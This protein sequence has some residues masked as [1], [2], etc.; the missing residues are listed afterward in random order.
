MSIKK[1]KELFVKTGRMNRKVIRDEVALSWY[2]CHLNHMV[3]N[4]KP[5]V[6]K[7]V[8]VTIN[9][10]LNQLLDHLVPISQDYYLA[11]DKLKVTGYRN[12][13]Y[14]FDFDTLEDH[15]IGTNAGAIA[16]K[17]NMQFVVEKEEHFLEAISNHYSV[18]LPFKNEKEETMVLMLLSEAKPSVY[19]INKIQSEVNQFLKKS[20]ILYTDEAN[21]LGMSPLLKLDKSK[22]EVLIQM[23]RKSIETHQGLCIEGK[24]PMEKSKV[25]WYASTFDLNFPYHVDFKIMPE[26]YQ[27]LMIK[28]ILSLNTPAILENIEHLG[29]R[30]LGQLTALLDERLI[31]KK[32][33]PLLILTLS[34]EDEAMKDRIYKSKLFKR[35][36]SQIIS[37]AFEGGAF[38]PQ[39]ALHCFLEKNNVEHTEEQCKRCLALFYDR[40][41][42]EI[43]TELERALK[44]GKPFTLESFIRSKL[45]TFDTLEM[46]DIKHTKDIY[47]RTNENATLTSKLLGIS[48]STLYRKL[49]R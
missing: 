15:C 42:S 45:D 41:W 49:E 20:E 35:I 32:A 8:Q 13:N 17:K 38:D 33:N 24:N 23:I 11:N 6:K 22:E 25:A 28:K 4:Q 34:T 40:Q 19:E 47:L 3:P 21:Q 37:L 2:K 1:A 16:L 29:D 7:R 18:G 26:D 9:E 30:A 14:G 43:E 10:K 5:M 12:E 36:E 46:C 44:E 39:K 27:V 31:G 48:R